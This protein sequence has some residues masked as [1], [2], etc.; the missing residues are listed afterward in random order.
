MGASGAAAWGAAASATGASV[1]SSAAPSALSAIAL[2]QPAT[3]PPGL[4]YDEPLRFVEPEQLERVV[5]VL[6]SRGYRT[7]DL[8]ALLGGNLMRLA[9]AVWKAPR[10][11]AE[12]AGDQRTS[13]VR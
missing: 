1:A 10:P 9:R 7:A 3:F 11:A 6:L 4:G 8:E 12:A 2:R 5:E 13:P